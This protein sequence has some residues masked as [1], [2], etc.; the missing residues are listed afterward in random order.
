MP[1]RS[2]TRRVGSSYEVNQISTVFH[3]DRECSS[4]GYTMMTEGRLDCR[5]HRVS[6]IGFYGDFCTLVPMWYYC[7]SGHP[8]L[9]PTGLN[10]NSV[11][12]DSSSSKYDLV[13]RSFQSLTV[14]HVFPHTTFQAECSD[15]FGWSRC[16][17]SSLHREW[18]ALCLFMSPVTSRD[19]CSDIRC[20]SRCFSYNTLV[21]V[22]C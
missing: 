12:I 14:F 19:F 11:C 5:T 21:Y 8:S 10:L 13:T 1:L 9:Y 2:V 15:R 6:D 4:K 7:G 16:L 20:F 18:F 22:K 17:C 3:H